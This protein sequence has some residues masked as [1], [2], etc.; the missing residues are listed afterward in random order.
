M[1]V[2]AV[3][4]AVCLGVGAAFVVLILL[5]IARQFLYIC[6][7][8][9]VL[10][11][12]GRG[13]QGEASGKGPDGYQPVFFGRIWRKPFLEK[14]DRMD[15]RTIPIDLKVMNAYS[16]G[17]IPLNVHAVA[18]V[19][20]SSSPRYL[21]NAVERFLNRDPAEIQRVA[22][23]TLEGHLRG[24][25]ARL[26]P[27]EV[28][29]DRLKFA[30]ELIH[31][32]QDDF[33]KLGL[34]LDTLKIQNVSDD[35][36]YLD[37]IG[38]ERIA[39]VIR[40]AEIAESNARAEAEQAEAQANQ[41]AKVAAETAETM[42]LRQT[43]ATRRFKA[44]QE[45]RA[46]AE[47]ERMVQIVAQARAEAEIELQ[48]IRQKLEET[49]RQAEVVLPA[50]AAG[51]A[52]ALRAQG[53]AASIYENGRARAQ[54]LDLIGQAWIK[55]GA[56]AKDIFLI[57]QLEDV[58]RAVVARINGIEVSEVVLLDSG[59]GQALPA[60]VASYPAMVTR[61]LA[62][63]RNSSGVDIAGILGGVTS[64]LRKGV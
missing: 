39:N 4:G 63:L 1:E 17:G 45:A 29:E 36:K 51:E 59:D 55:A 46:K 16:K 13:K 44:E 62:E 57:Q 32:A 22:K 8:H 48:T 47:E 41:L 40:D 7:P 56:D 25:L 60:Y 24:V 20:I 3:F 10:I 64:D 34:H 18:C 37:S 58:L 21:M 43:N 9:E 6:R 28:N 30:G 53:E 52:A 49:R 19:K 23:E 54:V 2:E 27:E 14:V 38:R 35:V 33:N 26:T 12:S 15:M 11:V 42:I 31:E 61:I 5:V 50:Q